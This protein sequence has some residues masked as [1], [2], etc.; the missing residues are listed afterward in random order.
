M[1]GTR[2]ANRYELTE[3]LGRGS[4]GTVYRARDP[5][6]DREVAIKIV[7]PERLDE[8]SRERFQREARLVAQMDHPAIVPIHDFG[9]HAGALY[10][11]MPLVRGVTLRRH[12]AAHAGHR[13]AA[14]EAVA[15][16]ATIADALSYSHSRDIVHRD[17]K[18]ENVLVG[19]D[20]SDLRVRVMDFGLAADR[21]DPQTSGGAAGTPAYLSPEQLQT[22]G[23]ISLDPRCDVYSLGT[24]LYECLAGK[25]PF[26]G[27]LPVLLDLLVHQPPPPLTEHLD[28]IDAELEEVV[29]ACLAKR[30]DDRPGAAEL[31]GTLRAWLQK[32]QAHPAFG[33][34]PS[35]QVPLVGRAR[36]RAL[37]RER[38]RA[39]QGGECQLVLIGGEAGMGKSRLLQ[40]VE[41]L[42]DDRHA[43]ILRGRYPDRGEI[44]PYEGLC[45]LIADG[46]RRRP[47]NPR[48]TATDTPT[49]ATPEIDLSDLAPELTAVFPRLAEIEEFADIEPDEPLGEDS[50]AEATY[51]FELLARAILRLAAGRPLVLL[52]EGLHN[53]G[54]SLDA[55]AYLVHR[56]APTPTLVVA[57]YRSEEILRGHPLRRLLDGFRDHPRALSLTLEPLDAD[58]VR[59]LAEHLVGSR[60][61]GPTL[62]D[63]VTRTAEG[64][65][66]FAQELI[67]SLVETG[68]LTTDADGFV[69]WIGDAASVSALPLTI[70]QAIQHRLERLPEALREVLEVA[71]VLGASFTEADL[72]S[73]LEAS[74]DLDDAVEALLRQ[75]LFKEDRTVRGQ[76]LSFASALVRD[77]LYRDLP[78]RRRRL[79][80]RRYAFHLEARSSGRRGHD[81]AR[82]AHHFAAGEVPEKAVE[83]ALRQA[84]RA[85]AA[86]SPDDAVRAAELGLEQLEDAEIADPRR[87]EGDLCH[88]LA[89]ALET[90]GDHLQAHRQAVRAA[91]AYAAADAPRETAGA[92]Y[93]AARAAWQARRVDAARRWVDRGL[94]LARAAG[95]PEILRR[96]LVLGATAADLRGDSQL[97]R[98]YRE[99]AE[100][101]LPGAAA[102][103]DEPVPQGGMLRVACPVTIPELDP[104]R[105]ESDEHGEITACVFEPLLR[106]DV[107]GHLVP[108]LA[109]EW[110]ADG[111]H[112]RFVFTLR[113]EALF[114]DG[115]PLTAADVKASLE[116]LARI[117]RREPVPALTAIDGWEELR[118][119]RSE[120]LRGLRAISGEDDDHGPIERLVVELAEPLPIFPALLTDPYTA[121]AREAPA[122]SGGDAV[123]LVGTGPFRPTRHRGRR[124]ELERNLCDWQ[125]TLTAIEGIELHT[126]L[127]PEAIAKG[128]RSGE[129]D[130]GRAL[131]PADLESLLRDPRFRGGLVETPIK[132]TTFLL[133]HRHGPLARH[134]AL[135]R[136]L[137]STVR[138]SELVWRT[139]GRFALPAAGLLPPGILGHDPGRRDQILSID[140]A[141][142]LLREAGFDPA[143]PP[144]RLRAVISPAVARRC[145]PLLNALF[146]S[147]REFGVE[148]I[149]DPAMTYEDFL[150]AYA[151]NAELDL[152]IGRW[153]ADYDDPDAF[154]YGLL[155][156]QGGV[157]R[158]WCTAE[159]P[160]FDDLIEQARRTLDSGARQILYRRFEER[161]REEALL[162]PLFHGIAYRLAG[163]RVRGL[164][165]RNVLPYVNYTQLGKADEEEVPRSPASSLASV[166]DIAVVSPLETFDPIRCFAADHLEVTGTVYESLMRYDSDARLTPWLAEEIEA[167]A[168]GRRY[169]VRL[170]SD[171]RFHDGRLLTARDVRASFERTLRG[172]NPLDLVLRPIRGAAALRDGSV[173]HLEGLEILANDELVLELTEPLAAFPAFLAHPAAAILPEGAEPGFGTWQSGA[174]GTGPFRIA[175]LDGEILELERHPEHWR[176]GYPRCERLRFT[177]GMSPEQIA[178]GFR[179]GRL[180]LAGELPPAE[181]E[182]LRR[183]P[184]F[185][186]GYRESPR[187]ETNVLV[188]N[189]HRGPLA[190]PALRRALVRALDLDELVARAVGPRAMR[191][192]GLIPPSLLGD[193]A[194]S[195]YPAAEGDALPADALRGLRLLAAVVPRHVGHYAA[196]WRTFVQCF[197]DLGILVEALPGSLT[198]TVRRTRAGEVDLAFYRWIAD[199]PDPDAFY[200]LVARPEGPAAGMVGSPELD[201]LGRAGRS[202]RDPATRRRIYRELEEHLARHAILV[203]ID[204][205]QSYRFAQ[206]WIHGLRV[207]CIFPEIYYEELAVRT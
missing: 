29:L 206:P 52:L 120:T 84:R 176:R 28:E 177:F 154:A 155:H 174:V 172:A 30:C 134:G 113:P 166:L 16:A 199:Y 149:H 97:A 42:A 64:N 121:I 111:E 9:R 138:V 186:R 147:W 123:V 25:P 160:L 178:D 141:R 51:V 75:G 6:L 161:L 5:L 101:L 58:D 167:D 62:I 170:R 108:V 24:V 193:E 44:S 100:R 168:S 77:T 146:E 157:L 4:T 82:L 153:N 71:A 18:P 35:L 152:L 66:L 33:E 190:D 60:R 187:L 133:F 38:L 185:A 200:Q 131:S 27:P 181:L 45:E 3:E 103:L 125:G 81:E 21:T 140:A 96:L 150:A 93:L 59:R 73:L 203:P 129:L 32:Q 114:S 194:P 164:R 26:D 180:A 94:E 109:A 201:R 183:D 55:L 202:E 12:L 204:H 68:A 23:G 48:P 107:D 207:G 145:G 19:R 65:P 144:L 143:G 63:R 102:L 196:L 89:R 99:E 192:R 135:R 173:D 46:F 116:R 191:A 188:L 47:P 74:E 67:C 158:H 88:T 70:R 80:H 86:W 126:D 136:A 17:I 11:V 105:I 7:P 159:P 85:L 171:V 205:E 79:L 189:E 41:S 78:P 72:E 90:A 53:A 69:E 182:A 165:L 2:L 112:R 148:V 127:D 179:D 104:A 13:L 40:E 198:E 15:I 76:P 195:T 95:D 106:F 162:L 142:D 128:M 117:R 43:R 8:G 57:T 130:L 56:L 163:P 91:D 14:L 50:A 83:H 118:D 98:T 110:E 184:T 122:P 119:G 151:D 39:A 124:I 137:A 87:R 92:A 156:S 49:E 132:N 37:L 22:A 175:H 169:R 115:T 197:R 10:F 139:L 20:S 31:A 1:I 61:L 36:E 54:A 34:P